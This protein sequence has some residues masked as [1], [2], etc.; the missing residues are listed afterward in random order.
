MGIEE[1]RVKPIYSSELTFISPPELTGCC[2]T[3]LL[4]CQPFGIC[5]ERRCG[6]G[7]AGVQA[8]RG[9]GFGEGASL[10]LGQLLR[11]GRRLTR[12][13]PPLPVLCQSHGRA[14][15]TSRS[16]ASVWGAALFAAP[17]RLRVLARH[18]QGIPALARPCL[19][20]GLPTEVTGGGFATGE[21]QN[22]I[23]QC[24]SP[25][26]ESVTAWRRGRWRRAREAAVWG[27]EAPG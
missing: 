16:S 12:L 24:L 20:T 18:L 14:H 2:T 1:F 8:G 13:Q 9:T 15:H 26:L 22:G 10:F 17:R 3:V 19:V 25:A 27:K 6:T 23:P 5:A 21:A 7:A 4:P 11:P